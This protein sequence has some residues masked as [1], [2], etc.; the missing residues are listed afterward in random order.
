MAIGSITF[1]QEP[2]ATSDQVPVITNWTPV[3]PYT[4]HQSDISGLF[5][6]KLILEVYT[7][8]AAVTANLIAKIKQRRNGYADDITDDEARAVFDLRAIINSSLDDTTADLNVAADGIYTTSIHTLGD[9]LIT[10]PFSQNNNQIAFFYV[11]AFQ[12]YSTS[13]ASS[14]SEF[15]SPTVNDTRLYMRASLPLNTGRGTS[16]FQTYRF[17]I[18]QMDGNAGR[19]LFLSDVQLSAGAIKSGTSYRNYVQDT[20]YHTLGFLNGKI[21]DPPGSSTQELD[22]NIRYIAV[23]YYDSDNAQIDDTE[24]LSNRANNGGC[25]PLESDGE[26]ASQGDPGRLIYVGCGPA[27]LEAQDEETA[28]RPSNFSGWAYY[29]IVGT[30]VGGSSMSQSYYFFKQDGSCK[31]FKVRRLAWI[32]SLGCWDYFNFKMKSSKTLKVE[33]N[34]YETMLGEFNGVMYQYNNFGRGKNT[35]S[36]SATLE[37][38]LN[39]D[40]ITEQD[41]E[42]LENLIM[43]RNVQIIENVD[44]TYTV[45]VMVKDKSIVRKTSANDGV[46]IQYTIKIEYANPINTN[47]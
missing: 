39:T 24:V 45:P 42:L 46:K 4:V 30:D 34:E 23:T 16:D 10:H 28:A 14:P 3:V 33:K 26:L 19:G 17:N 12:E 25:M 44:T 11:K 13:A 7:G 27:N 18:Y 8:S 2:V 20:D 40:W 21:T 41:A 9:N 38:T 32:N 36:T 22:S 31:G 47:S 43:S 1:K 6:F 37:E 29:K 5:Y 15:T 35:R